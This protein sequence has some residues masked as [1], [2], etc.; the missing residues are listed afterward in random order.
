MELVRFSDLSSKEII[1]LCDGKCLGVFADCDLRI[2]PDTGKVL[3]LILTSGGGTFFF[4][5][6]SQTYI[7]PWEAVARIGVDTIIVSFPEDQ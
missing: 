1:N 3:E 5:G 4:W 6:N 2:D 7:I